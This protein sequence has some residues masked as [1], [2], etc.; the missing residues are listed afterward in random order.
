MS[1]KIVT[2]STCDITNKMKSWK[3]F[4]IVPLTLQIDDY[5]IADDENFDQ[6]DF[7]ARVAKSNSVAKSACPSPSAFAKA[8]EGDEDEVY[9]ITI[10]D[11]LS[12]SY[13]SAVQ[14]KALYED[15]HNDGKKIYVF[16]SL[17]TSGTPALIAQKIK[18]V[19]DGGMKFDEVVPY[20]NDYIAN[21]CKLYF[22]LDSL[23]AL[24]RNGRLFTLAAS[25]LEKIHLKLICKAKEGNISPVGK[26][27][28]INRAVMK[29]AKMI[30]ELVAGQD[31]SDKKLIVSHVCC[32]ERAKLLADKIT[33]KANF[34]TVEIL[35]CSGLNTLYASNGG[36][37]VCFEK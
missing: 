24:K 30:A 10:T 27:M 8:M 4:E 14:G 23:D 26:D 11:K 21:H 25:L 37:I 33:E 32:E 12:G 34:G 13:N 29:M 36:I 6:D 15:E 19:C 35:K 17:A 1:Y 7:V 5:I 18:E 20:I 31:L 16:N 9:V 2:D 22:C 28:T 3:N